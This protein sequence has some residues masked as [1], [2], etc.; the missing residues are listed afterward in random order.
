MTAKTPTTSDDA[1]TAKALL[2][3]ARKE[4]IALAQ[5]T[6]GS[7]LLVVTLDH[8]MRHTDDDRKPS[9]EARKG[10][11]EQ[12]GGAL[13]APAPADPASQIEPTVEEDDDE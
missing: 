9:E 12:F 3:W 7:V 11:I 5:V 6:V 10:I 8:G 4:R 13:F 1:E 2:L